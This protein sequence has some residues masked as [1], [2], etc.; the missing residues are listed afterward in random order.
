MASLR[1]PEFFWPLLWGA[2]AFVL[3]VLLAAE[4]EFGKVDAGTGP[5]TPAKV[6]EARLIPPFALAPEAQVAPETAARPIF[7]PARRLSPP[8]ATA[9]AP[10]MRK[11]QFVLTGITVTPEASYVFLRESSTGKTKSVRRGEM[12]N[13]IT[14]DVVEP[15]RAV[16][17]QG[18]ETEDLVLNI[19]VPARMTAAVP[20][21]G[22]A[23]APGVPGA[24]HLQPGMPVPG[25][26]PHAPGA[27]MPALGEVPPVPRAVPPA[28]GAVPAAAVPAAPKDQAAGTQPPAPTPPSGRRRPWINAQ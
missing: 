1:R 12:V 16:L 20:A 6:V 11:G 27:V 3:V 7:V 21:S 24:V 23:P 4:Y 19:Q 2:L 28:P 18:E 10:V 5:R 17:R 22:Q 9:S 13:G 14:I 15:R 26:V 25:A 8:A